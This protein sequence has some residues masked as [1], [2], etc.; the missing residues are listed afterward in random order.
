MHAQ[1]RPT[2]EANNFGYYYPYLCHS[3][4]GCMFYYCQGDMDLVDLKLKEGT[5]KVKLGGYNL[6]GSG[7]ESSKLSP[8]QIEKLKRVTFNLKTGKKEGGE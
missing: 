3:I 5:L 7:D 2:S 1:R 4:T 8:E 6:K